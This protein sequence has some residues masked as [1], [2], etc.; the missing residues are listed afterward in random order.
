ML[1]R[2][3]P[4]IKG[5]GLGICHVETPLTRDEPSGGPA[6]NTPASLATAIKATGWDMCDT[7]SNHSLDAG[8]D[9]VDE[10]GEILYDAGVLHTGSFPSAAAQRIPLMLKVRGVP[11][12]FLSYVSG[13]IPG[14]PPNPNP[15][16]LNRAGAQRILADAREARRRGARVVIVNVHWGKEYE[17]DP[18]PTQRRLAQTLTAAP[19]ITAVIGQHVHVVQPIERVRGKPVVF[20]EGNLLSNQTEACCAVESQD[21]LIA[22]LDFEVRGK[23][24]RVTRMRYV[25]TWVKHP[26]FEVLPVGEALRAD[27]E[28]EEREALE[29]SYKDTVDV[30]GREAAT[31]IPPRLP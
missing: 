15:W 29:R 3:A 12:A 19:E 28:P 27:P 10:T 17:S 31:P 14:I 8:Q 6:F 1:E 13:E 25:P 4:V 18:T 21:G 7:T 24:A 2:V 11:L 22:L 26:E 16:S 30:V 9:G 23:T 20:G 5:A